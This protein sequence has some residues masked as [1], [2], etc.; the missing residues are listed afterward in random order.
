MPSMNPIDIDRFRTPA[1][2]SH[3][4]RREAERQFRI[5]LALVIIIV[6]GTLAGLSVLPSPPGDD[7][8]GIS[9]R[10]SMQR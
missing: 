3:L 1:G 2:V 7:S 9:Q 4:S 6:I 10:I 8:Y 5:G